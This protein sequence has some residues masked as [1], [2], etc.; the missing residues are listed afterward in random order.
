MILGVLMCGFHM[1]IE[2]GLPS[3][4]L[5]VYTAAPDTHKKKKKEKKYNKIKD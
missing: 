3:Y 5:I 2:V 1:E 4:P